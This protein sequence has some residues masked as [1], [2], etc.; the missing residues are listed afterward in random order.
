MP[1]TEKEPAIRHLARIDLYFLLRFVLNRKDIEHPWLFDRCREVQLNSDGY[2]DLW[3]R[4]HYKDLADDTPVLTTKGWS[5]HGDLK[6]G[7]YVYSPNG[8]TVKVVALSERYKNNHC[9]KITMVDGE[10]IVCGAGHLWRI[11]RKSKHRTAPYSDKR[12][13]RFTDE[14]VTTSQLKQL[15]DTGKRCDLGDCEPLS[16]PAKK[17]PVDPYLLGAWLGDGTTGS[18]RITCAYKDTELVNIIRARGIKAEE[19]SSSNE[20]SGSYQLGE[21]GTRSRGIAFELRQLGVL[22]SKH[23]PEQYLKSSIDQRMWL[24]RGLM[25]TDGHCDKT[26]GTATFCNTNQQLAKDVYFLATGLGLKPRFRKHKAVLDG[27]FISD[28]W[29]V[30]FQAHIDRNP[31][32]LTRKAARAI[33]PSYYRGSRYVKSVEHVESV[34]TRCI[35]VDS[36]DGLYLVGRTLLPTH[37]ST[38]IT[39]GKTIQDIL[40]SHGDD[41][42]PKYGGREWTFGIFSF[43]RPIAKGFLKQIKRELEENNYLKRLFSDVLYDNPQ[44]ESPKWSEDDGLIVKRKSNPKES[45]VEAWG[46]VE[47]QPTSKHF[48]CCIFDDVVTEDTVTNPDMVNK[49]TH[50]WENADNLKDAK[51]SVERTIGT[52]YA[53]GDTYSV[54]LDRKAAIPRIYPATEDG[55]AEGI[56][57]FLTKEE[58]EKKYN[59]QGA[60]TFSCQQLLDPKKAN[61]DGFN[62]DWLRYT[63][64][65]DGHG[66]NIYLLCDPANEKNKKSDYTVMVVIG[67]GADGNHYLL[68]GIR[69]RL[70]LPERAN[71]LLRMHRDWSPIKVGYEKYGKDADI[72]H[73]Q[74]V[75]ERENYRFDITEL[76]GKVSKPERIRWLI[77]PFQE[78]HFYLP[79]YLRKTNYEG[80]GYDFV[81]EFLVEYKAFPFMGAGHDDILD[82]MSRIKDPDFGAKAPKPKKQNSQLV[83]AEGNYNALQW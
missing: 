10:Q 72:T 74:T 27:R 3:A 25:D 83:Q 23:I 60:Y 45:T 41:P 66:L 26:R 59:K 62:D 15:V 82:C 1:D 65:N 39:F 56:P 2:L 54:M 53:Y 29:Q 46:L 28:M 42:L 80:R 11:R 6:V 68:D 7:D 8:T 57:V 61:T 34:P 79:N 36:S 78:G 55:T 48:V 71:C 4:G 44:K 35:Q 81:Q 73:I 50:A 20:N 43:N 9:L 16:N 12:E 52:R 77:G 22:N 37:N 5:K 19:R 67:V 69:D 21:R 18:A 17:L 30:S 49:T 70:N 31:F 75:Q 47:G 51:F 14:I 63:G 33:R 13:V 38:I 58:L 64:Y 24:L 32:A 40:G 76:G